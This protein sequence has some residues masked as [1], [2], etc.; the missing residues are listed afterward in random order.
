MH[1]PVASLLFNAGQTALASQVLPGPVD[2]QPVHRRAVPRPLRTQPCAPDTLPSDDRAPTRKPVN[3][4]PPT[5]PFRPAHRGAAPPA[6][7]NASQIAAVTLLGTLLGTLLARQSGQISSDIVV[8]PVTGTARCAER[9]ARSTP[10]TR[11]V[12]AQA[13]PGRGSAGCH[14]KLSGKCL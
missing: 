12:S 6:T 13:Q 2:R 7:R 11:L 8:G 1:A 10:A 4:H 3:L 5:A 14:G 9:S